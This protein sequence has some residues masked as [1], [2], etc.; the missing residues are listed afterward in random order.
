MKMIIF[1][2][3]FLCI[4]ICLLAENSFKSYLNLET[5]DSN[6]KCSTKSLY[7]ANTTVT[8]FGVSRI[9]LVDMP[10]WTFIC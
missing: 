3:S 1:V 7:D 9:D 5:D 6:Q 4:T 10:L 2:Y 8:F